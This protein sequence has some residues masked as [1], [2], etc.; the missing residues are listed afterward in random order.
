M[1]LRE[2]K[3][4]YDELIEHIVERSDSIPEF[5]LVMDILEDASND[6]QRNQLI[7]FLSILDPK[8]E[9]YEDLW[10]DITYAEFIECL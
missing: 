8:F 9:Q 7:R 4:R 5:E 2:R 1:T 10:S 6:F 3:L